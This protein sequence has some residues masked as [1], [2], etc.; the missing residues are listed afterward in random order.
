MAIQK[1]TGGVWNDVA[2][3]LSGPTVSYSGTP[4]SY[5]LI[6]TNSNYP[7]PVFYTGT[8]SHTSQ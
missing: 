6:L 8:Y 3:S 2:T 1:N 4:G 7:G 5:R